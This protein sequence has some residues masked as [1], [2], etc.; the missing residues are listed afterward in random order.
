MSR[1]LDVVR[2]AL[3]AVEAGRDEVLI[4]EMTRRSS[5][6]CR[7]ERASTS[8]SIRSTPCSRRSEKLKQIDRVKRDVKL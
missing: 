1:H 4:D 3:S 8:I 7:I 5:L 6:G 2:Q